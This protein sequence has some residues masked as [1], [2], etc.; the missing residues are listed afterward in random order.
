[1]KFVAILVMMLALSLPGLAADVDGKWTGNITMPTGD[2][3]VQFT[4]VPAGT[5]QA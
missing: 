3:P 1:M 2:I 4:R 5:S